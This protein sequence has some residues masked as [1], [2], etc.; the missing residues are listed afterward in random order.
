ME[1]Q[2]IG[3]VV[4]SCAGWYTSKPFRNLGDATH[5]ARKLAGSSASPVSDIAWI[6]MG[7]I[8]HIR[9]KGDN[10]E[11]FVRSRLIRPRTENI[12]SN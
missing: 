11:F 2:E 12:Q 6:S 9:W 7:S 4:R 3:F 8:Q 1:T 5:L 10:G